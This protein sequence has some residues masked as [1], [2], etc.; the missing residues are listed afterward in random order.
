MGDFEVLSEEGIG[1]IGELEELGEVVFLVGCEEVGFPGFDAVE[2]GFGEGFDDFVVV[3][4]HAG[5][6]KEPV[7]DGVGGAR[8]E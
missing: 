6:A 8:G 2:V 7:I 5:V 4:G 3:G 1:G